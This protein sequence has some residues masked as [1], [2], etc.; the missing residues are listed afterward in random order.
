M[1]LDHL[2]GWEIKEAQAGMGKMELMEIQVHQDLLVTE[3]NLV[4]MESLVQLDLWEKKV[5][6]EVM[7]HLDSLVTKVQ[8]ENKETL[9]VI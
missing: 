1:I 3:A 5:H 4:K 8:E 9:Y 7:V 2:G 6:Q